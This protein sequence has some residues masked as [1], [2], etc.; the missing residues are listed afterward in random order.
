MSVK[1]NQSKTNHTPQ[2][3]FNSAKKGKQIILKIEVEQKKPLVNVHRKPN[4]Q[5]IY[6]LN[7]SKRT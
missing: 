3:W 6:V 7:T 2:K 1:H 4:P 5:Y